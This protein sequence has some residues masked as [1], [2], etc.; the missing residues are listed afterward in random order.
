MKC[1]KCNEI[2]TYSGRG[3]H[4]KYCSD[5]CR[6]TQQT[7]RSRKSHVKTRKGVKLEDLSFEE[8]ERRRT[9]Q[10]KHHLM[11]TY[12][13]SLEQ[14]QDL[15]KQQDNSCGVC[16]KHKSEEKKNF[17]VDHNHETG[18]IRGLL[19]NYCN[20]RVI[21]RHKDPEIFRKAASYL[22][23]GTGWFVP[24]KKRTKKRKPKRA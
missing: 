18:E 2:L 1:Q 14:Y 23:K 21:G 10:R 20:R 17:H 11:S 7:I 12:G 22:D 24:K 19:C 4:P 15:L 16:G 13:I 9:Q 6:K 8:R 5:L 3:R